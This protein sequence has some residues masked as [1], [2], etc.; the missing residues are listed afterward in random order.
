MNFKSITNEIQMK[1]NKP[2]FWNENEEQVLRFNLSLVLHF[3]T[4]LFINE[5]QIKHKRITFVR[6]HYSGIAAEAHPE[7]VCLYQP[8]TRA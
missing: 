8:E 4:T 2:Y 6:H 7:S 3:S 5:I 1:R